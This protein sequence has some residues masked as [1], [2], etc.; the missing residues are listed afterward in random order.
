MFEGNICSLRRAFTTYLAALKSR[1]SGFSTFRRATLYKQGSLFSVCIQGYDSMVE[2]LSGIANY[3][4]LTG[5]SDRMAQGDP[6]C[7]HSGDR[8]RANG[9]SGAS[10]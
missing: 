8:Y 5:E 2:E 3:V 1:S 4:N 6:S 9:L 7:I 10:K